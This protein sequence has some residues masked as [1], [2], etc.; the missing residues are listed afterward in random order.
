MKKMKNLVILKYLIRKKV[1]IISCIIFSIS[2]YLV[3]QNSYQELWQGLK[4]LRAMWR[5][6]KQK[7]HTIWILSLKYINTRVLMFWFWC[8]MVHVAILVPLPL[9]LI[10]ALVFS[11]ALIIC[12]V[13]YLIF[14]I[15][16]ITSWRDAYSK[17]F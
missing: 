1:E 10:A 2:I 17:A 7:S 14:I 8:S 5:H 15:W 16:L 13:V 4:K 9:L 12:L 6:S 3:L 11:W